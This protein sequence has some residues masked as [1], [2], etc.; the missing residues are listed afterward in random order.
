MMMTQIAQRL[1]LRRTAPMLACLVGFL[2]MPVSTAH[3]AQTAKATLEGANIA[4]EAAP[5]PN[6]RPQRDVEIVVV[7]GFRL[8]S[9][10]EERRVSAIQSGYGELINKASCV[11][12]ICG[13]VVAP[14]GAKWRASNVLTGTEEELQELQRNMELDGTTLVIVH[15]TGARR[16]VPKF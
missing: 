4:V 15:P 16:S 5:Q 13:F 12:A 10:I 6:V 3:G 14:D 11:T 9:V 8:R 7:W 2:G 1:R